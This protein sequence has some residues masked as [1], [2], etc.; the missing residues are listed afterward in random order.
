MLCSSCE[1]NLC[2]LLRNRTLALGQLP[3]STTIT[4]TTDGNQL[5]AK[6]AQ[7]TT[8]ARDGCPLGV[9]LLENVIGDN[10]S[11]L[12]KSPSAEIQ[13]LEKQIRAM[14]HR[15]HTN[16]FSN[17]TRNEGQPDAHGAN[18]V[19]KA[20]ADDVV[21]LVETFHGSMREEVYRINF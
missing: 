6:R 11:S 19:T 9:F 1:D 21:V 17:T 8:W 16:S 20:A 14:R 2:P 5:S 3:I 12:P 4:S 15:A 10:P 13:N 18:E 7:I